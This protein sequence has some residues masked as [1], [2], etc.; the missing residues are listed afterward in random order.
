MTLS[1]DFD[2]SII[3]LKRLVCDLTGVDEDELGND[4]ALFTGGLVDSLSLLNIITFVEDH[5]SVSVSIAEINLENWDTLTS[6]EGY[7]K[8]R[9]EQ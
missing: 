7:L 5:F 2:T 9:M 8:R 1:A 4:E 3:E 6:I